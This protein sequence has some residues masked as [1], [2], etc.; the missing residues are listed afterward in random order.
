MRRVAFAGVGILVV[1]TLIV[2][3][4]ILTRGG[5][6]PFPQTFQGAPGA[7]GPGGPDLAGDWLL[8]C[9]FLPEGAGRPLLAWRLE[10]VRVDPR[11]GLGAYHNGKGFV[12]VVARDGMTAL[13]WLPPQREST[14]FFVLERE[15]GAF[16]L[17]GDD[18]LLYRLSRGWKKTAEEKKT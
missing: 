15:D 8:E 12:V 4:V 11:T 14:T 10:P 7:P 16:T 17:R 18:N 9:L 1:A 5:D 3:A 6:A 2:L 13:V